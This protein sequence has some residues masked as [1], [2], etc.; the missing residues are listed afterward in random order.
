MLLILFDYW[1]Y[2]LD[3]IIINYQLYT[4]YP[5][6]IHLLSTF[7]PPVSVLII[8]PT[9]KTHIFIK[10]RI[11]ALTDVRARQKALPLRWFPGKMMF[12]SKKWMCSVWKKDI[13]SKEHVRYS[14]DSENDY[15]KCRFNFT[16]V[17]PS[18]RKWVCL[19]TIQGVGLMWNTKV[20]RGRSSATIPF[21]GF[22]GSF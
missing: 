6:T 20:V 19:P 21:W 11:A 14:I 15:W 7:H 4:F 2:L 10:S 8:W 5:L 1:P 13:R 16:K 3:P 18:W 17:G 22:R 9:S 12:Q